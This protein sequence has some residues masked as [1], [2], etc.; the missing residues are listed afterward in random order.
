MEGTKEWAEREKI[1]QERQNW[2][3][4]G[5]LIHRGERAT[6]WE[7]NFSVGRA[8]KVWFHGSREVQHVLGKGHICRLVCLAGRNISML[9]GGTGAETVNGSSKYWSKI[10]TLFFVQESLLFCSFPDL[11]SSEEENQ[12]QSVQTLPCDILRLAAWSSCLQASL[13]VQLK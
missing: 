12:A 2:A 1:H 6:L 5:W 7:C 9:V 3:N 13:A 10:I 11:F 4:W 8:E